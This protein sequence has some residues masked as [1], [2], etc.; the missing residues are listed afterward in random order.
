MQKSTKAFAMPP[1][2]TKEENSNKYD[3][4]FSSRYSLHDRANVFPFNRAYKV[5]IAS[6]PA[7]IRQID[8]IG[9]IYIGDLPLKNKRID[10]TV[11]KERLILKNDQIDTLFNILYNYGFKKDGLDRLVGHSNCFLPIK[12]AL[13]FYDKRGKYFA[14]IGFSFACNDHITFPRD[15]YLGD[16]CKSKYDMIKA[17]MLKQGI[18]YGLYG[19][20]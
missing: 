12:N 9:G 17:F 3:C 16:F 6:F 13:V 18:T 5:E 4:V 11:F 1:P 10:F 15:I 2:E 7:V 14:Y 8:S 20:E 19:S